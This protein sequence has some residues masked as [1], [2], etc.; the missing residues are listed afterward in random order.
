[1]RIVDAHVHL[2]DTAAFPIPWFRAE[3][4]LPHTVSAHDLRAAAGPGGV[5]AA[6]AVQVADS[7]AEAHWLTALTGQD[8][9][10][11]RCVLQYEPAPGRPLGATAFDGA[12]FSG[13]R[14]AIPQAAADLSDV[15][16]LDAL[17]AA[18][19]PAG[20]VLEVLIRPGQTA[21]AAELARRHPDTPIVLCHLGLGANEPTADWLTGLTSFAEQ[22]N[23]HAKFS[24]LLS[25]ARTD[26][27]LAA[28]AGT[29]F[30]LFGPARLLF[31]SDWPMSA[32]T[33]THGEV[34]DAVRRALP[35]SDDP[36]FWAGT[37]DRLY[38]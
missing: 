12:E 27:A 2:W 14:A 26:A 17:A 30:D 16:G 18:L 21:G 15:P 13:I 20:R 23:A 9:L 35:V 37:S 19:G 3:L 28:L 32:R 1:M 8:A 31:G 11:S 29:A 24:G 5:D 7:V 36:D 6:I 22:P 25:P 4:G 34:V 33:H 10:A 38:R